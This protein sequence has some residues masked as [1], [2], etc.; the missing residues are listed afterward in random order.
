LLSNW[1][2]SPFQEIIVLR[3]KY[4]ITNLHL[5]RLVVRRN[6][7]TIRKIVTGRKFAK[8]YMGTDCGAEAQAVL[9]FSKLAN[10]DAKGI[11][12]ED[13]T[14]AYSGAQHP[15]RSVWKRMMGRVFYGNW[16]E[17][18]RIHATSSWIDELRLTFPD[19]ARPELKGI[20]TQR[21]EPSMMLRLGKAQWPG[22]YLS[23]LGVDLEKLSGFD[24]LALLP[25]SSMVGGVSRL[26]DIVNKLMDYTK[27]K[28]WRLGIKCHPRD[29]VHDRFGQGDQERVSFLPSAMPVE[30]LYMCGLK[31]PRFIIAGVS[32]SLLTARWLLETPN[33][34]SITDFSKCA[35]GRIIGVF[36]AINIVVATTL[37]DIDSLMKDRQ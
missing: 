7:K 30:L 14:A 35:D 6:A 17:D 28:N 2:G 25:R 24:G 34:I 37:G 23:R 27:S 20:I 19:L 8:V 3:E 4:G 1:A 29:T 16:W 18:I 21:I 5:R 11:Y 10:P 22:E 13:G 26:V 32:T 15:V 33:V 12:Y 31:A 9:H 36:E